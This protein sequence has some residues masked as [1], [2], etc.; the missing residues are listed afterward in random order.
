MSDKEALILTEKL[1][2]GLAL[3]ERR[4]LEEKA[5]HGQDIV[6]CDDNNTI[7]RIPAS[8]ALKNLAKQ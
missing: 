4:M 1:E 2:Y 3:A 7:Q 5:L 8:E 6:V